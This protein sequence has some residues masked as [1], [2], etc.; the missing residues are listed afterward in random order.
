M[1]SRF[2]FRA[3]AVAMVA[4]LG[5]PQRLSAQGASAAVDAAALYKTKCAACHL[6]NG[7]PKTA[8]MNFADGTW[9]HGS[10]VS[11]VADVIRNGV[12]GTAMLPFK[13]K[14]TEEQILALTRHVRAFDK[15]LKD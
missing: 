12:K 11:Q 3:A 1:S 4:A 6:A 5:V 7:A 10:S 15:T 2:Y 8:S 9:R 14:L 13:S